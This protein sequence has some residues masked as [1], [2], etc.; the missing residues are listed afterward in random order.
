[1]LE[2]TQYAP[3]HLHSIH[4]HLDGMIRIPELVTRCKELNIPAVAVTDH[5]VAGSF[6]DS[7]IHF[8]NSG[9]K[10][11]YGFEAYMAND[12]FARTKAEP[13]Y[14]LV[15]LAKNQEGLKNILRLTSEG[16]CSGFYYKPRIDWELL[17]KYH[18]GIVCSTAC[19][20]GPVAQCILKE[21]ESGAYYV[22][23][24]LKALFGDDFYLEMQPTREIWQQKINQIMPKLAKETNTKLIITPDSHYLKKEDF[25]A[26]EVMLCVQTRGLMT[27][28]TSEEIAVA[29]SEDSDETGTSSK[30]KRFSFKVPDYFVYSTAEIYEYFDTYH[31]AVDKNIVT[32][33]LYNTLAIAD[34]CNAEYELGQDLYPNF[35]IDRDV[36]KYGEYTDWQRG[37]RVDNLISEPAYKLL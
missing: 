13:R 2:E 19:A 27:D 7:A 8:R 9:V 36:R 6:V 18:E 15:L 30:K 28:P 35:E 1:M 10:L 32:E 25:S 11:I 12:R 29:S 37:A 23:S 17:E 24:R 26:H 4:S 20:G 14:H 3:L 16:F 33:S 34:K 21:D 31:S 5:G 22:I